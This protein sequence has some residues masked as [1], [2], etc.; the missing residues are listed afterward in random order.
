[1]DV[2]LALDDDRHRIAF[3]NM[4]SQSGTARKI[5]NWVAVKVELS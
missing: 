5:P 3:T 4:V 1:M 2:Y